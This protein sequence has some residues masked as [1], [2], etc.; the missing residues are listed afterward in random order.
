MT[1]REDYAA[2]LLGRGEKRA[3]RKPFRDLP[4]SEDPEAAELLRSNPSGASLRQIAAMD[5]VSYQAIAQIAEKAIAKLRGEL[6]GI[7]HEIPHRVNA[8]DEL[9]LW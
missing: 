1:V 3:R 5:G 8:W 7:D 6:E 9:A 2:G 4:I